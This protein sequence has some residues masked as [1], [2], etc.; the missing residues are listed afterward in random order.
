[1]RVVE[2]SLGRFLTYEEEAV[3]FG[4]GLTVL[5]GRNGSGKSGLGVEAPAW[6]L[7]GQTVRGTVPDGVACGKF[8]GPG[9]HLWL[10]ERERAGGK[11]K[12]LALSLL[13]GTEKHG[14]TGQTPTETQAKID[15]VFGTWGQHRAS[16]V[17]S[18][19]L[20][21]R[22]GASTDKERKALLETILGL[23]RFELGADRARAELRRRRDEGQ[24]ARSALAAAEAE[25]AQAERLRRAVP[26]ATEPA[27]DLEAALGR[28][29]EATIAA[30][31]VEDE[32]RALCRA[33]EQPLEQMQR[34][35]ASVVTDARAQDA[36]AASLR[37]RLEALS[38]ALHAAQS[39]ERC[40]VCQTDRAGID[41]GRLADHF[42]AEARPLR[43]ELAEAEAAVD[44]G[45]R[46]ALSLRE[47]H[48][49]VETR[50]A[51]ALVAC[52]KTISAREKADAAH[53]DVARRLADARRAEAETARVQAELDR[54]RLGAQAAR[55]AADDAAL[56]ASEA[57]A[58]VEV[59]GPRGARVRMLEGALAGIQVAANAALAELGAPER[60]AVRGTRRQ[61]TGREVD[62]VSIA[63]EGAG[64][65]EYDGTSDGERGSLDLGLLLGVAELASDRT[66]YM[67]FDEVFDPLDDERLEGVVAILARMARDR[68]V[69]VAT[70][71]P[72]FL[73]I[74]PPCPVLRV[75][76]D[77]EGRS[78]VRAQ[79][80]D[81]VSP[82][83]AGA[84][85]AAVVDGSAAG[86]DVT[87]A[88]R[89]GTRRKRAAGA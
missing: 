68:Q 22:F 33:L 14:R 4:D 63:V 64:G 55:A 56:S 38:K 82:S 41:P 85:P 1:M 79:G 67:A 46:E 57:E 13:V 36:R 44:Q 25:V 7:W 9:G 18:Q 59:L 26:V 74:L 31:L 37:G 17:F 65:G 3:G 2:L 88:T 16:R 69:V 29:L 49:A 43:A 12:S 30:A 19:R 32:A 27:A 86:A 61:K 8:E 73:A 11:I 72:R 34:T 54:A 10:V 52:S 40:P 77:A 20:L 24:A 23:E 45:R 39:M 35:Y 42:E 71:N 28:A 5:V 83:V 21:A 70:H 87:P 60:I 84:A 6:I 15:D 48:K 89:K 58:A 53:A 47:D 50:R 81:Q 66:G 80:A 75:E 51:D 62:E 76:R 78:R